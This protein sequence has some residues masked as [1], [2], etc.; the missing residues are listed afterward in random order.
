MTQSVDNSEWVMQGVI[1]DPISGAL[2]RVNADGSINVSIAGGAGAGT[3][4]TSAST[5][6]SVLAGTLGTNGL[7]LGVP[8][9][10]TNAAGGGAGTGFTSTTTAGTAV[11]GTLNSNG[12]SLGVP[13]YLT[14]ARASTDGLGLN[15]AGTNIT[16]TANSSGVSIN[17]AGYAGTATAM[18]SATATLN[19]AGLSLSI[20]AY[21]TTARA[22]TDAIGLNTAN[23]NVTWTVNSSGISINAA[24]YAGTGTSLGS[25]VGTVPAMT[26]NSNGLSFLNP[27]PMVSSYENF[28]PGSSAAAA[29]MDGA[30][31]SAAMPFFLPQNGSFSFIR[32][33]VSFTTN[34]TTI[35]TTGAS[36]SASARVFSTWNAVVYSMATGGNSRSLVYVAS[37]QGL[38]TLENSISVAANGT[39]YSVSQSIVGVVEGAAFTSSTQYSISNTNYSFVT[40]GPHTAFSGNR[41]IDINFASSLSAGPYWLVVGYSS[42]SASNSTGIQPATNCNISFSQG[43]VQP[44]FNVG[45]RVMGSTNSQ[46]GQMGGASFSTAGGGT[47]TSFPASALTSAGA[48][49]RYYFQMIRSA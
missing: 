10:L 46:I 35:A 20:G 43:Y 9:W 13:A 17:A 2:M 24:G 1:R 41:F 29:I 31:V 39:Q 11:V 7:S 28:A 33:P 18:T 5:A 3:G 21:I 44:G 37:G 15:T 32:I 16:W 38:W 30:S 47:T 12:L 49:S 34:S 25:T 19:S 26:L 42:N 14:T 8:A 23:T 6:G 48:N 22:S 40:S 27:E 4:F 45:V 36:L